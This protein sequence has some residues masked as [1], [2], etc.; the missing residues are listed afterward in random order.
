VK[1]DERVEYKE[2]WV[3][4]QDERRRIKK[5]G[6]GGCWWRKPG[7]GKQNNISESRAKEN[8]SAAMI[9]GVATRMADRLE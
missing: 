7:Q 4:V 8:E 3:R 9:R 1:A 5:G 6:R 2:V